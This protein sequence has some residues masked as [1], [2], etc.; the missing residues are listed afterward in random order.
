MGRKTREASIFLALVIDSGKSSRICVCPDPPVSPRSGRSQ[1]TCL[2]LQRLSQ[3][4]T[5]PTSSLG[6]AVP[7]LPLE[8][9]CSG[10]SAELRISFLVLEAR[11]T[12]PGFTTGT[13]QEQVLELSITQ[14][15]HGSSSAR[16][17]DFHSLYDFAC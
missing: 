9:V 13:Q 17:L 8:N 10:P 12:C 1:C 16:D 15:S 7:G 3:L 14:S 4:S 2:Y 5:D 6:P 11:L